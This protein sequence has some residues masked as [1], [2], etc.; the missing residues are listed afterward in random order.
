MKLTLVQE[1]V[2]EKLKNAPL[3]RTK[4]EFPNDYDPWIKTYLVPDS[5]MINI[6]GHTAILKA[7]EKKGLIEIIVLGGRWSDKVRIK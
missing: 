2:M 5:D 1:K 4:E 7:L 6:H 3:Q